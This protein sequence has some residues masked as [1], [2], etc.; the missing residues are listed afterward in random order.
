MTSFHAIKYTSMI[1]FN[2]HA[3]KYLF[4]LTMLFRWWFFNCLWRLWP[5]STLAR[6]SGCCKKTKV[7]N[8]F[9]YPTPVKTW[10]HT[11]MYVI[12]CY[13]NHFWSHWPVKCEV[14]RSFHVKQ[15]ILEKLCYKNVGIKEYKYL[16]VILHIKI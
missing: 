13:R 10:A 15:F 2:A 3:R 8:I 9:Y 12:T 7:I 5:V 1:L 6:T 14:F 11:F 16:I 4:R